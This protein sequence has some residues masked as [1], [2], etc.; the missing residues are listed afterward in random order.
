ML[1]LLHVRSSPVFKTNSENLFCQRAER[2]PFTEDSR[3]RWSHSW[4]RRRKLPH[5]KNHR[6]SAKF[7]RKHPR[8]AVIHSYAS[9]FQDWCL[10]LYLFQ[11]CP[12]PASSLL[13]T[14]FN[15]TCLFWRGFVVVFFFKPSPFTSPSLTIPSLGHTTLASR[16]YFCFPDPQMYF[17]LLPSSLAS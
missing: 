11:C 7:W 17:P 2:C 9:T 14:P 5:S 6:F 15:A 4:T 16:I 8:A 3:K 10:Q 1:L 12:N 13:L